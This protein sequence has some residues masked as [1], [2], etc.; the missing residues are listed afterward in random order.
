MRSNTNRL[1]NQ[2]D[3]ELASI[4]PSYSVELIVKAM[5]PR[6]WESIASFIN[7]MIFDSGV[8]VSSQTLINWAKAGGWCEQT[9]SQN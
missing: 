5:R 7:N 3:T 8:S 2:I 9:Q 6:S 4:N 1:Q